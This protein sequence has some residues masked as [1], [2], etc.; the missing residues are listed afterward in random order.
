[1]RPAETFAEK[2][3]SQRRWLE[4]HGIWYAN[5]WQEALRMSLSPDGAHRLV[6]G[7]EKKD[8]S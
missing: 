3:E 6:G 4:K 5:L 1:M 8:Q 2:A 7:V